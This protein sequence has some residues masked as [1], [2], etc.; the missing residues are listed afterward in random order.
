MSELL[1]SIDPH[2]IRKKIEEVF[3]KDEWLYVLGN[4][5]DIH[6][7]KKLIDDLCN[8]ICKNTFTDVKNV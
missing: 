6:K 3:N 7:E 1:I 2:Y 4:G 5:L 8:N